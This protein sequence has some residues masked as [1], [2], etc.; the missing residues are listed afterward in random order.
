MPCRHGPF[1]NAGQLYLTN[2]SDSSEQFFIFEDVT[3]DLQE[4]TT[5]ELATP[6]SGMSNNSK[7]PRHFGITP[8]YHA[9]T[10][11]NTKQECCISV[12]DTK[13]LTIKPCKTITSRFPFQ[14]FAYF[15]GKLTLR[16]TTQSVI[17]PFTQPCP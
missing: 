16:G 12:S 10:T 9:T 17:P 1:N 2:C 3:D 5:P 6:S 14:K 11:A 15:N 7:V 8:Q 4:A 13:I